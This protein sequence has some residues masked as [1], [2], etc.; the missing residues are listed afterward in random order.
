MR[1]RIP[2]KRHAGDTGTQ[3]HSPSPFPDAT[4]KSEA[5]AL[6]PTSR[7]QIISLLLGTGD[8]SRRRKS[9]PYSAVR[10]SRFL[11][12]ILLVRMS[13]RSHHKSHRPARAQDLDKIDQSSSRSHPHQHKMEDAA[14]IAQGL[15]PTS[16][17]MAKGRKMPGDLRPWQEDLT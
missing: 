9:P 11:P 15:T 4:G 12:F 14:R 16:S 7:I 3:L 5:R 1:W 6:A 17:T 13:W 2:S 8:S 10:G